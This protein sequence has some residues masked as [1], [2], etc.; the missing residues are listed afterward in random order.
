LD[1]EVTRHDPR[2]AQV[3]VAFRRN[4]TRA[5]LF[6]FHPVGG[7][8][9]H[10]RM[11]VEALHPEQPLYGVQ[12]FGLDGRSSPLDSIEAMS[13]LYLRAVKSVQPD[14]PYLLAGGSMGGVLALEVAQQMRREGDAVR[15]LLMFD[16]MGPNSMG[17]SNGALVALLDRLRQRGEGRSVLGVISGALAIR[18][19]NLAREIRCRT[20][21][22]RGVPLSHDDRHWYVEQVSRRAVQRY[23]PRV[24]SGQI[25]LIRGSMEESGLYSDPERGWSGWADAGVVAVGIE[26]RHESLIEAPGF[27]RCLRELLDSAAG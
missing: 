24:Y 1:E 27:G 7:N 4:G 5:P 17:T 8:V 25:H 18:A 15:M 12:A 11:L 16:T 21:L 19:R 26:G 2:I 22:A 14:G 10:Y 23:V 3:L 9:L 6:C 20:R 13:S